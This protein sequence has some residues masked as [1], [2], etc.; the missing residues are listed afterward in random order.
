M[1]SAY[2]LVS[3][4]SRD[5]RP[6]IAMEQLSCLLS[7]SLQTV[8]QTVAGAQGRR[9]ALENHQLRITN[10]ELRIT[11]GT[12]Y[13]ELSPTPLHEQIIE[14]ADRALVQGYKHIEIVPL[15]LLS[16]VHVMEDIPAEV[17]IA[18]K[19]L[20]Q[21]IKLDIKPHLGTHPGLISL[22]AQQVNTKAQKWILLAHGSRRAGAKEP[23]EAI[24]QQLGALSAY[25]AVAPSLESRVQKLASAGHQEIEIIP[26]FLFSGGITDAI[27]Q[28]VDQLQE[29]FPSV[30]FHLSEPLGASQEL[31]D[32]ILD[33]V[34]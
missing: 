24:A 28:S 4:G 33:L 13:L 25:W 17:A 2:L 5:P 12:A 11:V 34:D 23:V 16:G 21:A 3:H 1:P 20:G 14:F 31:A 8:T 15:F 26:Y 9:G 27:A 29:K 30:R 22:L 32:L 18:Q 7:Q 10:Q 19:T 6:Q